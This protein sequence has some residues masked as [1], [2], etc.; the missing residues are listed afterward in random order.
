MKMAIL[1]KAI[2]RFNVIRVQPPRQSSHKYKNI[3]TFIWKYK[4]HQMSKAIINKQYKRQEYS[5]DF[6]LTSRRI[7][8][9]QHATP[10]NRHA[11]PWNKIEGI[12][13]I[14]TMLAIYLIFNKDIKN[15]EYSLK[16]VLRKTNAH[17]QNNEYFLKTVLRKPNAHIQKQKI[18]AV[19][20]TVH[21]SQLQINQ[22]VQCKI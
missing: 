4:S 21:K 18:R 17:I 20:I 8:I 13:Y 19:S 15:K 22:R 7:A 2:Y 16:T 9:K 6:K 10:Q 12:K 11:D 14:T 5:P 1:Y 3:L